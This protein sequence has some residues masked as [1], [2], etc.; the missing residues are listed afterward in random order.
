MTRSLFPGAVWL[1]CLLATIGWISR[2]IEVSHD[3]AAFLPDRDRPIEQLLLVKADRGAVSR[4]VLIG[5]AGSSLDQR[6]A[7]SRGATEALGRLSGIEQVSNGPSGFDPNAFAP[8][9]PYRYLLDDQAGFDAASLRLALETRLKELRSPLGGTVKQTLAGDPT[10]GFR[11]LLIGWSRGQAPPTLEEGLWVTP[12]RERALALAVIADDVG[13]LERDETIIPSIV[14]TLD[15]VAATHGVELQ[16]AGRPML[17]AEAQGSVRTSLIVGSIGAGLLVIFLLLWVYRSFG[18]LLLGILPLASGILAGL[19]AVLLLFGAVHGIA[20]A[21]GMTL[22]GITIDYPLH[23]FSHGRARQTMT[24]TA[25]HLQRPL[26]LS[27]LTTAFMFAIFGTGSAPGLGQL[28]CFTS[29]GILVA[30]LTLRFVVPSLAD[31]FRIEP[32]P[33]LFQWLPA[34]A[35]RPVLTAVILLTIGAVALLIARQDHLFEGDIGVLNPLPASAKERDRGLRNDLGASDLRHLLL[36]SG[37]SADEVLRSAEWLTPDL[38]KARKAGEIRGYDTPARYLPSLEKQAERRAALPDGRTL[39]AAL[40]EASAGLPF[41]AGLFMPFLEDVARSREDGLL[42]AATGQ[43]LFAETPLGAKL[44]QLMLE[45]DQHWY[46]F[47]PVSGVADASMLAALADRSTNVEHIDLKS[48]SEDMLKDFREEAFFLLAAG[49][50]A[51]LILLFMFRYPPL[52]IARILL[53][54][55]LSMILTT[56]MLS[57]IGERLTLLHVLA[58]LLVV[59]LGLDYTIF[60]TWPDADRDQRKRTRH[61]LVTCL[62][63]TVLV[64]GLLAL[65]S[66]DLLRAIG[67]TVALG[68]CTT[69]AVAYVILSRHREEA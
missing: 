44:D 11:S 45:L 19:G 12:D 10:A 33:R 35:A 48:F 54:L 23:L 43:R 38:E 32:S 57:L 59:G 28:A 51:V 34:S 41:K 52:G 7:A 29:V 21:F 60:F 56:A 50:G 65:S 66:I 67:L 9:Y 63:S 46:G 62:L 68:A 1:L 36:V 2:S 16:L 69:F 17:V 26:I 30:A 8:L 53:V 61:A 58:G 24:V 13:N 5:F 18:V 47:L 40:E 25:L 39:E 15:E 49:F 42:D 55:I 20:L 22:L 6:L 37:D 14:E 3:L 31:C 64:F 4:T 27:A